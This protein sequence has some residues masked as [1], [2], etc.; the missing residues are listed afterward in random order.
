[1]LWYC[2]LSGNYLLSATFKLFDIEICRMKLFG[3]NDE[4]GVESQKDIELNRWSPLGLFNLCIAS[5]KISGW[6]SCN[7]IV[8]MA[9]SLSHHPGFFTQ[10]MW[11]YITTVYCFIG[12]QWILAYIFYV[13]GVLLKSNNCP[14]CRKQM[15]LNRVVFCCYKIINMVDYH[16]KKVTK[17]VTKQSCENTWDFHHNG[18][19]LVIIKQ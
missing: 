10:G 8:I 3:N 13:H 2:G 7:S 14:D 9:L 19:F 11:V 15:T 4:R 18:N 16:C 6:G 5:L 1:M 17:S 12:R